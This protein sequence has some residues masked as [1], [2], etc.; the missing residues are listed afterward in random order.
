MRLA[1]FIRWTSYW[2]LVIKLIHTYL[3]VYTHT[4]MQYSFTEEGTENELTY[5]TKKGA[6]SLHVRRG[7]TYLLTP[8]FPI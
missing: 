3:H 6:F 8:L 5:R 1:I 7:G 4:F 2:L